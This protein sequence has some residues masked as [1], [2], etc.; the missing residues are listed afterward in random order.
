MPQNV[1]SPGAYSRE[2]R[3]R[4]FNLQF[5]VCLSYPRSG[6][7]RELNGWSKN[8]SLGGVLVTSDDEVPLRTPVTLTM[9]VVG[10]RLRRPVR[11]HGDGEVVRVER[12][13]NGDGFAIAVECVQTI[14]EIEDCLQ[15]AGIPV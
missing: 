10:P 9:N 4:R 15:Q 8:V 5:P 12:L 14:N 11:L 7:V 6:I 1:T 3:Y 13:A 2:R